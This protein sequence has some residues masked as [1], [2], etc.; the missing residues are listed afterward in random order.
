MKME[1]HPYFVDEW[2]RNK[3]IHELDYVPEETLEADKA[4]F[5][6][7]MKDGLLYRQI[8]D[9]WGDEPRGEKGVYVS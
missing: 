2:E 4:K 3:T 8:A 6:R 7:I 1:E 5:S 9:L